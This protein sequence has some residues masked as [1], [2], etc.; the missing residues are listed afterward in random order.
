MESNSEEEREEEDEEEEDEEEDEDEEDP[1]RKK[2]L[3][4]GQKWSIV[5]F[6]DQIRGRNSQQLTNE[7]GMILEN[8]F[9]V[10]LCQVQRIVADYDRQIACG[11][12]NP[13]L[14]SNYSV[15]SQWTSE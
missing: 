10:P 1:V 4:I 14:T 8:R 12:T 15:V 7:C 2:G 5:T 9:K 3:T 11:I 6:C 13:D